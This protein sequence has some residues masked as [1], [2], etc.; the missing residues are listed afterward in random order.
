M[1]TSGK[2]TAPLCENIDGDKSHVK[3]TDDNGVTIE[4]LISNADQ[5][6]QGEY[7][8]EALIGGKPGRVR[9]LDYGDGDA[10]WFLA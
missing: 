7:V 6:D 3:F 2:I 9:L 1:T 10:E 4:G 5:V 8:F